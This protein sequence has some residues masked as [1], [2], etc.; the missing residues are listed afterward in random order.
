MK[1]LEETLQEIEKELRIL[2][3]W[4]DKQPPL[5]DLQSLMPFCYDTLRLPQW[6]QWVFLPRCKQMVKTR[7]GIPADSDI[8]A[9][10]EY[11]FTEAGI[12]ANK[13]LVCVKHFDDLITDW[14]SPDEQK[15]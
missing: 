13:L 8:H 11:Y 4:E 3:L 2:K 6:L 9:I 14:N 12:D 5:H 7:D 1:Q 15:H 10:A